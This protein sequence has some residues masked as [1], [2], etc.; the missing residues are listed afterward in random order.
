MALLE[1]L[2]VLGRA[3]QLKG[4]CRLHADPERRL[5]RGVVDH[6]HHAVHVLFGKGQGRD[7]RVLAVRA[8]NV[9]VPPIRAACRDV[10][11]VVRPDVRPL[12]EIHQDPTV[13]EHVVRAARFDHR[14]VRVWPGVD[15]HGNREVGRDLP[16]REV[17]AD[18]LLT[19]QEGDQSRTVRLERR[20]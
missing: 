14:V 10:R 15:R 7:G 2:V 6:G 18:D 19:A 12:L 20:P 17:P 4:D 1:R 13:E 8:G 9:P 11:A 16:R 3:G 5:G